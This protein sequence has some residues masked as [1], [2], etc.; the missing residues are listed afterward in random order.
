MSGLV[1]NKWM[2]H[3]QGHMDPSVADFWFAWKEP[4]RTWTNDWL[5]F[6]VDQVPM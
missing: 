5:G 2:V 6:I 1:H 4:E 3:K